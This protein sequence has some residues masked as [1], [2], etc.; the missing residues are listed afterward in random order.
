MAHLLGDWLL[1][2]EWQVLNKARNARA[3]GAHVAVYH[4][5]VLVVLLF[6][7]SLPLV[8]VIA[9]VVALGSLHAILDRRTAVRG[10]MKALR[11]TVTREHDRWLAIVV[12]QTLHLLSLGVASLI[13]SSFAVR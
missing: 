13:L 8:P 4:A 10:L 2:T 7:Y 12:D 3:L 1:Q 5:V 11:L 9:V 6:G